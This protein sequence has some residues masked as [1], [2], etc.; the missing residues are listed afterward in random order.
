[1]CPKMILKTIF[2]VRIMHSDTINLYPLGTTLIW[3][4][5]Q[6]EQ[7]SVKVQGLDIQLAGF[8]YVGSGE[9]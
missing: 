7:R 5:S 6:S 9:L 8:V 1:M 4:L 2:P 3:S